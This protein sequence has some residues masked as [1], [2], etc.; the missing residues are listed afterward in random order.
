MDANQI[1][2]HYLEVIIKNFRDMKSLADRAIVQLTDE[3]YFVSLDNGESNSIAIIM[4]H[5]AGN[6]LSRWTDIFTTDGEKPTRN[7]DSEFENT[8]TTS[9]E[10]IEYWEKG[11][12]TLFDTL[13]S[14]TSE[15]LLR[16]VTIRTEPHTVIEAIERQVYHYGS[17]VGQIIYLAKYLTGQN[18][19]TLSIPRG[20][21]EEYLNKPPQ[22][23]V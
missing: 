3:Q 10:I 23:V 8:F 14:L 5:L 22:K 12:Y 1:G 21:S 18:W 11:W 20:K 15:D 7:R 19:K 9:Q 13:E 4:K 16:S 2:K 6:M 17:H